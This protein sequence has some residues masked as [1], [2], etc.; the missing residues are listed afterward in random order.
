[1]YWLTWERDGY[2]C[3]QRISWDALVT[4]EFC[5]WGM[6]PLALLMQ[7]YP[8]QRQIGNCFGAI[9]LWLWWVQSD[10]EDSA[11]HCSAGFCR[12]MYL[13]GQGGLERWQGDGHIASYFPLSCF[14]C[15]TV[16][17]AEFPQISTGLGSKSSSLLFFPFLIES[18]LEREW[19]LK[20]NLLKSPSAPVVRWMHKYTSEEGNQRVLKALLLSFCCTL[21]NQMSWG[22]WLHLEA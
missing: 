7:A 14:I 20:C 9:C 8:E 2:L 5:N 1:M 22:S 16:L 17:V 11:E 3:V 13:L 21:L 15:S 4:F 6:T 12:K 18:H 19:E 10:K